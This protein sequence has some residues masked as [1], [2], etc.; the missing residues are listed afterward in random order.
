MRHNGL[1][2]TKRR[3]SNEETR[4]EC[5]PDCPQENRGGSRKKTRQT[6]KENGTG[7]EKRRVR[8]EEKMRRTRK[9]DEADK[10][11]RY[12]GRDEKVRQ[13]GENLYL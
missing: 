6:R 4:R 3:A 2:S 8:Q 1:K 11:K 13:C 12:G 10:E 5:P 9:K 7:M